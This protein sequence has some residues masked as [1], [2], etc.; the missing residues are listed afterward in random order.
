MTKDVLTQDNE[1]FSFISIGAATRNVV[2]YLEKDRSERPA[3]KQ[4]EAPSE[5]VDRKRE[6][7]RFI[8]TR[9]RE[10][11]RFERRFVPRNR[12]Y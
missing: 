6:Q 10:I 9:L 4:D 8:E 2:R 7:E 3:G 12:N 5:E 11:E 1:E